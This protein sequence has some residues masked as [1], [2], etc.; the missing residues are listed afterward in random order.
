MTF[1]GKKND[2]DDAHETR[3]GGAHVGRL[4][5][6]RLPLGGGLSCIG[7]VS[8]WLLAWLQSAEATKR[9]HQEVKRMLNSFVH[10]G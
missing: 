5:G 9:D 4:A 1:S 7:R 8:P 6:M 3:S 2:C 10:S